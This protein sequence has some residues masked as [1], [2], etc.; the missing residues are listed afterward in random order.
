MSRKRDVCQLV[1]PRFA[2]TRMEP[3]LRLRWE[4]NRSRSSA[5]LTG[6]LM[7]HHDDLPPCFHNLPRN[8]QRKIILRIHSKIYPALCFD[9]AY[10]SYACWQA[11]NFCKAGQTVTCRTVDW[12][13]SNMDTK[14]WLDSR[15]RS[16]EN[17]QPAMQLGTNPEDRY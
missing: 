15:G 11:A 16:D 13:V 4:Q 6:R 5:S 9:I 12:F 17:F 10:G 1:S 2:V 14:I 8:E 3:K 7:N